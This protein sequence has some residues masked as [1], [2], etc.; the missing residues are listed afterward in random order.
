MVKLGIY[1]PGGFTASSYYRSYG[2]LGKLSDVFIVGIDRKTSINTLLTLDVFFAARPYEDVDARMIEVAKDTGLPVWVDIDDDIWNIPHTNPA[3]FAYQGK[4]EHINRCIKLA[5][6]V[7]VSTPYLASQARRQV[8]DATVVP[9]RNAVHKPVTPILPK[10]TDKIC[11]GWRGTATHTRDLETWRE[12]FH[13][14]SKDAKFELV[15][16]GYIPPWSV[17]YRYHK[18]TDFFTFRKA[19]QQSGIDFLL[20]P[21]ENCSFNMSKSNIAWL[22]STSIGATCITNLDGD[23]WKFPGILHQTDFLFR[24]SKDKLLDVRDKHVNISAKYINENLTLEIQNEYRQGI[25][26][27]L[28]NL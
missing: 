17:N 1:E 16:M 24:L 26:Q 23:E 12:L 5:D 21:L 27:Q 15:F 19:F 7:T 22:E 18:F 9:L 28:I 10:E 25:I 11:I 3:H 4:L 8:P 2:P 13:K 14:L 6:I 20:T